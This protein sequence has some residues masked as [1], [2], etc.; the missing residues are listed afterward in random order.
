MQNRVFLLL[1]LVCGF[2][3]CIAQQ[4]LDKLTYQL[5]NDMLMDLH[6][7]TNPVIIRGSYGNYQV[8]RS[9]PVSGDNSLLLVNQSSSVGARAVEEMVSACSGTPA[10]DA[11]LKYFTKA[12]I[13]YMRSQVSMAKQF[14]FNQKGIKQA[15]VKIVMLDTLV[16]LNKRLDWRAAD[17]LQQRYGSRRVY[18]IGGLLFSL[19]H[20]KALAVVSTD[21]GWNVYLYENTGPAWYRKATLQNGVY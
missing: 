8:Q 3:Q 13:N 15:G 20:R 4:I 7:Q 2:Q 5:A 18:G 21:D 14:V 12:D 1:L 10:R 9:R 11:M 16:A 19:D 6:P 17:T